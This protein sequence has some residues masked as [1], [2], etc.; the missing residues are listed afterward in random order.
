MKKVI[1]ICLL[2]ALAVMTAGPAVATAQ[3]T[4]VTGTTSLTQDQGSGVAPVVLAK[5]ESL[6]NSPNDDNLVTAGAQFTPAGTYQGDKEFRVCGVVTD[7]D[8]MADIDNVYGDIWY[9]EEIYLGASHETSRQGCGQMVQTECQMVKLSKQVGFETFCGQF[10]GTTTTDNSV[11]K[12]NNNLP[13]IDATS[14]WDKICKADGELMKETAA[15]YC[16]DRTLSYEDPSGN[17][18]TIVYAQDSVGLSDFLLNEFTYTPVTAFET[19]FNA[20][21]Y[22]AVK[23]ETPKVINGDLTW[24]ALNAGKATVRNIGN[25]RLIVSVNQDDMTFGQT[26]TAW[27]VG[28]KAR[29]GNTEADWTS[30]NP[31]AT[32]NLKKQMDLSEMNEMDFGITIHKFPPLHSGSYSGSMTLGAVSAAHLKTCESGLDVSPN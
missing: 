20:V 10:P 5:F 14:S 9:P 26:G 11:R 22:G 24:D 31:N 6:R 21:P 19:D 8:G 27:N 2:V 28:Y 23:L 25:T 3:T 29:V 1:S 16:C 17:Y 4:I 30:Y 7:A 13:T 12:M 15:V 18:E 32:T